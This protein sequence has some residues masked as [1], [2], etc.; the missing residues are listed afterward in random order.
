MASTTFKCY[1]LQVSA[2]AISRMRWMCVIRRCA[3]QYFSEKLGHCTLSSASPKGRGDGPTDRTTL[4]VPARGWEQGSVLRCY[5]GPLYSSC[6]PLA[7]AEE[8]DGAEK[9]APLTGEANDS[10][11]S[12]LT[13]H[14]DS[15]SVGDSGVASS[16]SSY[17]TLPPPPTFPPY[18]VADVNF[19]VQRSEREFDQL[20]VRL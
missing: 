10:N 1:M 8:A 16:S 3:V 2:I 19:Q 7:M 9:K 18:L 5:P 6:V 20:S 17:V 14:E 13:D 15:I 4:P 12:L 11:T